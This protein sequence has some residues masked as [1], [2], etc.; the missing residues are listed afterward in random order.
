M[1]FILNQNNFNVSNKQISTSF[2]KINAVFKT[3]P[4]QSILFYKFRTMKWLCEFGVSCRPVVLKY[5]S[6]IFKTVK[7]GR[8]NYIYTIKTCI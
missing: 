2:F 3:F 4:L 1:F 5:R 8:Y 6:K 7:N